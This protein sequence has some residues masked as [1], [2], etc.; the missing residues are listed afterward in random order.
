MKQ[1]K[2]YNK[3]LFVNLDYLKT[4]IKNLPENFIFSKRNAKYFTPII[5]K[6]LKHIGLLYGVKKI[7]IETDNAE[8]NWANCLIN[9]IIFYINDKKEWNIEYVL[10][11]FCHEIGHI[12]QSKILKNNYKVRNQFLYRKKYL[13]SKK[14]Y[15]SELKKFERTAERLGYFIY[16]KYFSHIQ[17]PLHQQFT[18]Y[19]KKTHFVLLEEYWKDY[20][21]DKGYVYIKDFKF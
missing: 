13:K 6:Q 18:A 17:K 16:K 2:L 11:V 21:I 7:T 10:K 12:I 3:A 4:K 19:N 5:L 20:L 1:L 9:E 14:V 15:F 8:E